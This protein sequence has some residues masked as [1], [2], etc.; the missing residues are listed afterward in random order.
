MR[1]NPC[2]D[3]YSIEANNETLLSQAPMTADTYLRSALA[4]I[5]EQLG[6]DYAEKHPEL[7]AALIQASAMDY[8]AAII[9]RAIETL[10]EK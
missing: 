5:D 7:V 4:C 6:D 1:K 9:A 8:G 2:G 3:G 10:A